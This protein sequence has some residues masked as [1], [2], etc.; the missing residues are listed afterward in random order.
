VGLFLK[1]GCG[2]DAYKLDLTFG[3]CQTEIK[4]LTDLIDV[5]VLALVDDTH[6][7]AIFFHQVQ[8]ANKH[9]AV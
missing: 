1:E 9:H 6:V 2:I 5:E 4:V 7:D 3:G 8:E